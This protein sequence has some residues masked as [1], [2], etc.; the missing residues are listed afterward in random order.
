MSRFINILFSAAVAVF[1]CAGVNAQRLP[2]T[3][4][5]LAGVDILPASG[6]ETPEERVRRYEK[7]FQDSLNAYDECQLTLSNSSSSASASTA[8]AASGSASGAEA[9]AGGASGQDEG[10]QQSASTQKAVQI[11]SDEPSQVSSRTSVAEHLDDRLSAS[12]PLD[13]ID[14]GAIPEDIPLGNDDDIVAQQI[15]EAA[16]KEPDPEIAAGLW[17]DYRKYKGLPAP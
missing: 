6:I 9:N 11:G 4:C 10:G 1:A 3:V 2:P 15:R 7:A 14:N 12:M 13:E 16:M 17:E 8:S 5:D